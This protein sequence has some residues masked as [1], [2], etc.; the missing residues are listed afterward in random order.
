MSATQTFIYSSGFQKVP[1][2]IVA[3]I[4]PVL[5]GPSPYAVTLLIPCSGN[6]LSEGSR[7]A[8]QN[9]ISTSAAAGSFEPA[10]F[11]KSIFN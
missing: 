9:S 2:L 6:K 5:K 7:M 10:K 4:N 8:R 3:S 11:R 1:G